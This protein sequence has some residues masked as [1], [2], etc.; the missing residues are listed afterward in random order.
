MNNLEGFFDLIGALPYHRALHKLCQ[1]FDPACVVEVG[2]YAGIGA[3]CLAATGKPVV[4]I[5]VSHQKLRQTM[6]RLGEQIKTFGIDGLHVMTKDFRAVFPE[7]GELS[8]F[9]FY[10]IHDDE[11]PGDLASS[12]HL[13]E[14]WIPNFRN[15]I[16][17]VHDIV[18]GWPGKRGNPA[19]YSEAEL[20]DGR[21]FSGFGECKPIIDL[22]N[23]HKA[24]LVQVQGTKSLVY[25]KVKN[26]VPV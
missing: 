17:A 19:S 23:E 11:V 5:D 8:S 10:D 13:I 24:E 7:F 14:T 20:W 26:G 6:E 1:E 9:V 3:F 22:L 18:E 21:K 25:F 2:T 4:T 12:K 16:F 15:A